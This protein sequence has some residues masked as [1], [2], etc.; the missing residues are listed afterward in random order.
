MTK[1]YFILLSCLILVIIPAFPQEPK[2]PVRLELDLDHNYT[3]AE[4]IALPDSSLLLYARLRDTWDTKTTFE[5]TKYDHL[6]NKV[7]SI[8]QEIDARSE[9]IDHA[10]EQSVIYV[11]FD[12]FDKKKYHLLKL[13]INTGIATFNEYEIPG[14]NAIYEFHVLKGHYLIL[15]SDRKDFKPTFFH[16]NAKNSQITPLPSVYGNE[17]YFSDLQ[18]DHAQKRSYA[19]LLESNGRVSHLQVKSFD[20][21]GRL[22]GTYSTPPQRDKMLQHAELSPGDSTFKL[23]L[24]AYGSNSVYHATGFFTMP[25]IDNENKGYFYSFT[26]LK[27]SL[28]HL[29]RRQ[30]RRLRNKE[31]KRADRR[32]PPGLRNKVMLH[33]VITTPDGYILSAEVYTSQYENSMSNRIAFPELPILRRDEIYKHTQVLV[34][35]FD[36]DGELLWDNNFKLNNIVTTDLVPTVEVAASPDGRVIVAYPDEKDIVYSV[37]DRDVY[38]EEKNTLELKGSQEGDKIISVNEHGIIRWYGANFAAFG[39]HRLRSAKGDARSVFY[40]NKISFQ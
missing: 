34:L 32:K 33:D 1:V 7:W 24:G 13:D 36:K 16:L 3:T 9:Y 21:L 29:G 27:N 20:P 12:S 11:A 26:D 35:A 25:L 17:S 18:T 30:E 40:I 38:S 23:L 39:F 15:G 19:V 10:L 8:T 31:Q 14:I 4:V 2:Q 37:M 22:L 5:F 28:K 6:L